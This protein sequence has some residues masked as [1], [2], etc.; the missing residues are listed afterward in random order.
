MSLYLE[1]KTRD[2]SEYLKKS[3]NEGPFNF[4]LARTTEKYHLKSNTSRRNQYECH[5]G[6]NLPQITD[7]M[8]LSLYVFACHKYQQKCHNQYATTSGFSTT[9]SESDFSQT[10]QSIIK[11][12][13]KLNHLEIYPSN[14]QSKDLQANFK[15]VVGNYVPDFLVFGIKGKGSSAV[16][17][18]IDGDSHL[19]KY[20]KDE[21]RFQHL[22]ELKIFTWEIPN[23]QAK[24]TSFIEKAL[25]DMYRLRNGSLNQQIQRV[26]RMI[27]IKT[28]V[29]QLSL[30]EIEQY[31]YQ[32]FLIDLHLEDEA[33]LLVKSDKCPRSIRKELKNLLLR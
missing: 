6:Y 8:L 32:Q 29:C 5:L 15:M 11:N 31:I 24:D 3:W 2:E 33:T 26:K 4:L 14:K 19:D 23:A 30:K 17:I 25:L 7:E 28:I 20:S 1:Q 18:E 22:K 16:A 9:R 12:H 27:W 13:P 21:L 10:L